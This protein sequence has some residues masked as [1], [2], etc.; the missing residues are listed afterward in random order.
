MIYMRLKR[1]TIKNFRSIENIIIDFPLNKPVAL[2][3][4]NNAGK[5]N[6]FRALEYFLG[7]RYTPNIEFL[8][9]DYYLRDKER[10]PHI[11][12]E[13]EFD[14]N[15]YSG[16]RY[17]SPLNKISF[18]TNY[19]AK[20]ENLY[21]DEDGNKIYLSNDD[22]RKI[23][24]I[25]IDATRDITKQLSY[26]S[27]Y[28]LLSKMAKKM[29]EALVDSKKEELDELFQDIK[30]TFESV[31]EYQYFYERLQEAFEENIE[32]FE[33][34]LELDL[35]A[36]DPNNYFKSLRVTAKEGNNIRSFEEFGT[37][38]QQILLMSFAKAYAET[39]TGENFILGIEEPEVHLHPIAQRWLAKNIKKIC[40]SGIQV[41]ITTH[42]PEFLDIE[43]LEG[44]IKVYKE[45]NIT[46][47]V[48]HDAT[49]FAEIYL[50]LRAN[51]NK[52]SPETIL[53]F[54]KTNTF[55]DQLKGLFAKKIILVEGETELFALPNYFLNCGYDLD[56]NGVE[57]VN[58]RGKNQITRNYRLFRAY[59]YNCFCLFDA[60]RSK[61][62][63]S[64]LANTFGFD[65]EE[66]DFNDSA[67]VIDKTKK[68]GYFGKDFEIYMRSEFSDYE[69]KESKIEG[70]KPLKAKIISEESD[71]KPEFIEQIAEVLELYK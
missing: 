31:D 8:D 65:E 46:K 54:Y 67:F 53:E 14:G 52:T 42:S 23:Q 24:F 35:S 28:S 40:R 63:N 45:N 32:G 64:D 21:H 30:K 55:Y 60:D 47:I 56:K 5:S 12:F 57:I 61:G 15:Y 58:C 9:S 7:E 70:S 43:N 22:R 34:K 62:D 48:Q 37:G 19:P 2:F 20:G 29:H 59:G 3:G 1:F 39:F 36:Y 11:T 33:H 49:S 13:A 51:K 26:F 18:T 69:D 4:P 41:V 44:F 17:K 38:E 25:S 6:I 71:Y 27:Q 10:Y 68:Y 66:M 16:S 50:K